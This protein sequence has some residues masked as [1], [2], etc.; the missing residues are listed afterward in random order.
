MNVVPDKFDLTF[1]CRLHPGALLYSSNMM[2][3]MMMAKQLNKSK[4]D[5]FFHPGTD[6]VQFERMV[7]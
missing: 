3:V 5:L 2:M 6:V 7:R 4:F 1:D